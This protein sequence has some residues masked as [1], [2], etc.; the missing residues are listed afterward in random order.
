[1]CIQKSTVKVYV[2]ITKVVSSDTL[3]L[4]ATFVEFYRKYEEPVIVIA[5]LFR[6]NGFALRKHSVRVTTGSV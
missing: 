3:L 5:S 4:Q 2:V 6:R 1:M